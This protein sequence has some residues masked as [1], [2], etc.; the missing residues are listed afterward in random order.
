MNLYEKI[1]NRAYV[2]LIIKIK[3]FKTI[4]FK[5]FLLIIVPVV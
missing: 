5:G 3:T 2:D 4:D 1:V